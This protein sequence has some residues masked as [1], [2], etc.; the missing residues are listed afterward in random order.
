MSGLAYALLSFTDT[1]PAEATTPR[2]RAFGAAVA[3]K[4]RTSG[5]GSTTRR[6]T[7]ARCTR[8]YS[9]ARRKGLG[10]S[11]GESWYL[12]SSAVLAEI[13]RRRKEEWTVCFAQLEPGLDH[14]VERFCHPLERHPVTCGFGHR[15]NAIEGSNTVPVSKPSAR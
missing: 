1:P 5:C 9:F 2:L 3:A 7:S 15:L 6:R 10:I 12:D 13:K 11:G 4:C 8:R 14:F